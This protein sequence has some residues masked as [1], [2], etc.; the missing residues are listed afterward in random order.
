MRRFWLMAM[1]LVAG[2]G[3]SG[4]A[5]GLNVP[6]EPPPTPS[7][8]ERALIALIEANDLEAASKEAQRLV[9]KSPGALAASYFLAVLQAQAGDFD[10]ALAGLKS[11][12]RNQD[13]DVPF[14]LMMARIHEERAALGPGGARIGGMVRYQAKAMAED[15]EGFRR[16]ELGQAVKNLEQMVKL[17]PTVGLYRAKLVELQLSVGDLTAADLTA[18]SALQEFPADPAVLLQAAKVALRLERWDE[19]KSAAQR[20]LATEPTEPE[21]LSLLAQVA[22][23]AGDATAAGE[24]EQQAR[25]FSFVPKFLVVPYGNMTGPA[26]LTL[27][28]NPARREGSE[29]EHAAWR[30]QAE[31]TINQ[32]IEDQSREATRLLAIVA[33][34]HDWHGPVEK[35][36][37]AEL[38]RRGAEA[39][40]L[41]VFEKA[42][43]LCTVGS[44]APVLAR[45]KS[46]AAFLLILERLPSDQNMFMMGLPEA[47]AIYGRREAVPVLG[48][49]IR[50][51]L[52]QNPANSVDALMGGIGREMLL[53]RC[54]WSLSSFEG[55]EARTWLEEAAKNKRCRAEATAALF[56]QGRNK[57]DFTALIKLLKRNPDEARSI[58]ERFNAAGLPEAAAVAA[59]IPPDKKKS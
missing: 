7:K 17:R 39:E 55:T 8:E 49:T 2:V 32:L 29:E 26:V 3:I 52:K 33:W 57:N 5:A 42:N 27:A 58:A 35:R 36:I 1:L 23:H 15:P 44:S 40:L 34:H 45:L 54:L 30:K 43:S 59:L 12:L 48:G 21:V 13:S 28:G 37:Y 38:E 56:V 6:N 46:D 11:G 53:S 50:E 19:A 18:R 22:A 4:V 9:K 20:C 14:L 10:A 31:A 51:L 41:A 47:L 24:W 16:A 25:Y